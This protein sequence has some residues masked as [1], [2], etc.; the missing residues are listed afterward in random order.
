MLLFSPFLLFTT[1]VYLFIYFLILNMP[2]LVP[3]HCIFFSSFVSKPLWVLQMACVPYKND[4]QQVIVHRVKCTLYINKSK[5]N[6]I[7]PSFHLRYHASLVACHERS[8]IY[9]WNNVWQVQKSYR[10]EEILRNIILSL[11]FYRVSILFL[12]SIQP[13]PS[14]CCFSLQRT[15]TCCRKTA[16]SSIC[17]S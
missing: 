11:S 4:K 8:T 6:E 12:H 17:S 16:P 7:P 13:L 14:S 1:W 5:R 2:I 15:L 9:P 10:R 3:T